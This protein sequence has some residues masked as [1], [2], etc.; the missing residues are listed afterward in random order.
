[1]KSFIIS[2]P[3]LT[4]SLANTPAPQLTP[5]HKPCW[6]SCFTVMWPEE[7][8]VQNRWIPKSQV[9]LKLAFPG[10]DRRGHLVF[11]EQNMDEMKHCCSSQ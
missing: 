1:M 8:D 7:Q 3:N 4:H 11:G 9:N 5:I 10:T 2:P 6:Y